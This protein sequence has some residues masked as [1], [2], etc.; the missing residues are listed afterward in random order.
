MLANLFPLVN[1]TF[2]KFVCPQKTFAHR[3]VG[4]FTKA[5]FF[6]LY[7]AVF[8]LFRGKYSQQTAG[9][10]PPF[11]SLCGALRKRAALRSDRL[12][13]PDGSQQQLAP[14]APH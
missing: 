6:S 10:C 7:I 2:H 4:I 3:F 1:G 12:S 11:L 5:L 13:L 14:H 8:F 9:L